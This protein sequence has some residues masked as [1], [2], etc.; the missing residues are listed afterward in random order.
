VTR[1]TASRLAEAAQSAVGRLDEYRTFLHSALLHPR[2]VGAATPTTAAVAATVGQVVP[3]TGAPVVVELGPGTGSLSDGIRA[4]LPEGARH[5]G[6]ELGTELVEHLRT[7]KPWLEVVHGDASDL[8]ALLDKLHIDAPD[9]I[10][11]SIPW[12]L[13]PADAQEHTLRQAA[14]A[15]APH[16]VFTALTY[17]PAERST[18]GRHFREL[19]GTSFDEVLTTT[20][21]RC[22]PPILHYICRRP[23]I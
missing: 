5:V 14:E 2:E 21:W 7:H 8:S 17:L 3:T 12:S 6:I 18:G 10:I 13:L 23:L 4:R 11:S 15:L 16:G 1:S 22:V 19:L 9:A 20:T